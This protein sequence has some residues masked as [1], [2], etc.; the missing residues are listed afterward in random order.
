MNNIFWVQAFLEDPSEDGLYRV[1][2]ERRNDLL[3]PMMETNMEYSNGQ[4]QSTSEYNLNTWK[5]F[6]W[7]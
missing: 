5:V 4:W 2:L 6:A 3:A 1:K 7:K